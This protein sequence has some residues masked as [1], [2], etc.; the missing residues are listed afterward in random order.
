MGIL[1]PQKKF[2]KPIRYNI[3]DEVIRSFANDNANKLIDQITESIKLYPRKYLFIN[4]N[5][6]PYTEK[7]L[8]KML[9]ELL[10]NKNS[11]GKRS[12]VYIYISYWISKL[13]KNQI[14]RV[15]F[16]MRSSAEVLTTN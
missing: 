16:L 1:K 11:G 14:N 9:S 7:G 13:T 10:Q 3:N 2:Q 8:Q 12:T 5:D 6:K 4:K 15:V